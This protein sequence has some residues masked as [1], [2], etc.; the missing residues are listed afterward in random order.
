LAQGSALH[1]LSGLTIIGLH[2]AVKKEGILQPI[3]GAAKKQLLYMSAQVGTKS[4]DRR[5][6]LVTK[7]SLPRRC[8][9]ALD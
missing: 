5:E 7:K 9:D 4:G 1:L 3:S 8:E 6:S 2:N